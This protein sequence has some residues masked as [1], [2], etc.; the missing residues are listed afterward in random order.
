[1]TYADAFPSL[2]YSEGVFGYP[3]RSAAESK[4]L[5]VLDAPADGTPGEILRL[6]AQNDK[7]TVV[8]Y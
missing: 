5:F 3:E 2:S 6:R 4:D 8:D 7:A 1:M